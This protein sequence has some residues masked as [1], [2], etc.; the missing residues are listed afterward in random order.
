M[1][2]DGVIG[3][4]DGERLRRVMAPKVDGAINL[5]ELTKETDLSQFVLFSSVASTLG[6]PGQEIGRAHV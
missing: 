3:S 6:N 2:D 1:L 5:H 4:L